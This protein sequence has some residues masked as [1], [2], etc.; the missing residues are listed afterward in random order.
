MLFITGGAVTDEARA[1]V[2]RSDVH[3]LYKPVSARE[4]REAVRARI[5]VLSGINANGTP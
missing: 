3:V 5:R 2:E 4:I 1:F